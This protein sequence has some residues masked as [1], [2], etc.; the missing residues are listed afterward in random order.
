MSRDE[1]LRRAERDQRARESAVGAE[2]RL[3][4]WQGPRCFWT[5]RRTT[6]WLARRAG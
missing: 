3:T 6:R 5:D 2:G 4:L 1:V